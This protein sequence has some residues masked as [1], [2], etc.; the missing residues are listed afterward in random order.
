[1]ETWL[2]LTSIHIFC[3][4]Q[5]KTP[6]NTSFVG[7]S[8]FTKKMFSSSNQMKMFIFWG[9]KFSLEVVLQNTLS[10]KS[11]S[12]SLHTQLSHQHLILAQNSPQLEGCYGMC[13]YLFSL[14]DI[15]G[16]LWGSETCRMLLSLVI[17]KLPEA[18]QLLQLFNSFWWYWC[19]RTC[20]LLIYDAM[21]T[22]GASMK[23]YTNKPR[24]IWI[25]RWL[26]WTFI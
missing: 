24:D 21:V 17:V 26:D 7:D 9:V 15:S 20:I 1:M 14:R 25:W 13:R 19:S 18:V 10:L 23:H 16:W 4:P 5:L 6:K 22:Q 12:C 8:Y 3:K 2:S 11:Y